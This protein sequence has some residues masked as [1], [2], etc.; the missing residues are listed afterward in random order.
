M[1]Y[2][3]RIGPFIVF[4]RVYIPTTLL[5]FG[6]D[7]NCYIFKPRFS[8]WYPWFSD[9][10]Y[11]LWLFKTIQVIW[12]GML[13]GT[14]NLSYVNPSILR[15]EPLPPRPMKFLFPH[16]LPLR[17]HAVRYRTK[18]AKK[19][20]NIGIQEDPAYAPRPTGYSFPTHLGPET[21]LPS[22][23]SE[24][25]S[26]CPAHPDTDGVRRLLT[27]YGFWLIA[28]ERRISISELRDCYAMHTD[29]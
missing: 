1:P 2:R 17:S 8:K 13:G 22:D 12:T 20:K 14:Q 24:R 27:I 11:E 21:K 5:H 19:F 26:Q 23:L 16:D 3:P 4:C 10:H 6:S 7:K 29:K 9:L 28:K 25:G 18:R 15:T